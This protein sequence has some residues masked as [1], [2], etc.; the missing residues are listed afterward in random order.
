[1]NSS[2]LWHKNY[3]EGVAF[4][5]D[6]ECYASLMDMF[7]DAVKRHGDRI[8][9][10]N[11]GATLTY[12]E[13]DERSYEFAAYLQHKQ[14]LK[15]GDR[16]ALMC[17]NTLSFVVAMWAIIRSGAIQV[18][19]NPLY[20]ARELLH[21]LSDSGAQSM[22]IFNTAMPVLAEIVTQTQVQHI[23]G[24]SLDDLVDKGL[25]DAGMDSRLVNALSFRQ[26]LS[27]GRALVS[28]LGADALKTPTL[29]IDDL[30]FLQYTGGTTGLSKGAMLSHGNILANVLQYKEYGKGVLGDGDDVV[31]TA[32]PLYHIFALTV[33]AICYFSYGAINHLITNPRDMPGFVKIWS[34][35]KVT[36]ITGVNTLFNGLL[37][38]P[39]FDQLDFSAIRLVVGGGAPVQQAVSERW[40]SVTGDRIHVGY[41]LSETSP[42]VCLDLMEEVNYNYGIGLAV[43]NTELSIRDDSGN[44][45]ATGEIGELCI[46]GPQVMAGYWN[47][48]EATAAAMTKDGFFCSGDI[49]FIDEQGFCH[50]VDRKKDMILVSGFNVYPNE[51]EAEVAKMPGILESACIGVPDDSRGEAV[52]LFAVKTDPELSE[53][54]VK[55]FCREGLASYKVPSYVVFL[56]AIPKSVVGK[57]LRRE[58]RCTV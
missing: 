35:I 54:Q 38:T 1:M 39:G 56:D 9:Y 4:D 30:V 49:A 31:I 6:V 45:L 41:G 17:P 15:K 14:G 23:V 12:R 50:I 10:E 58:L 37:H 25:V 42:L 33:N 36:F 20:T 27:E 32:I 47:N 19:V 52:K 24:I 3:P 44:A 55:D 40:E 26:A 46:K 29:G 48:P 11:F 8:A 34:D 5:V 7:H 16:V 13:L 21:Q 43:P 2:K 51:I 28:E 22:V 57:I 53:E 18:S